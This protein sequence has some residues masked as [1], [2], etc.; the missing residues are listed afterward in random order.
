VL[1]TSE[2]GAAHEV[3]C[4]DLL[5]TAQGHPEIAALQRLR[6]IELRLLEIAQRHAA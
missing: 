2:A 1:R 6:A 4:Y 3:R 5:G